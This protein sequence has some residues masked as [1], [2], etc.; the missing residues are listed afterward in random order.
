MPGLSTN[1]SMQI[2]TIS[3]S[4][5]L[6][7]PSIGDLLAGC[8]CGALGPQHLCENSSISVLR[9]WSCWYKLL[10]R[11]W[12]FTSITS[13]ILLPA[14]RHSLIRLKGRYQT[15]QPGQFAGRGIGC[16]SNDA[17]TL[18]SG[19]LSFGR[20]VYKQPLSVSRNLGCSRRAMSTSGPNPWG[21]RTVSVHTG[22]IRVC[23]PFLCLP[24]GV[25]QTL[26]RIRSCCEQSLSEVCA[27]PP[28]TTRPDLQMN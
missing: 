6:Y 26:C 20:R 24:V 7:A 18:L 21:Q 13:T 27:P 2:W 10:C 14:P 5:D 15:W 12:P 9:S 8:V 1:I 16:I 28:G 19:L 25:C 3:T 11:G 17:G 23:R 4:G 22:Q